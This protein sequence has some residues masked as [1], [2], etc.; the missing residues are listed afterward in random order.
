MFNDRCDT[1]ALLT[2]D[3]DLTPVVKVCKT[4]FA[5]KRMLFVFPYRRF[6]RELKLLLPDS[7]R[8]HG[9]TYVQHLLPDPVRLPDGTEIHKPR[10]W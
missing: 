2:G 6:N 9:G 8:I 5:T 10:T 1:V 7:F 3:T 4:L